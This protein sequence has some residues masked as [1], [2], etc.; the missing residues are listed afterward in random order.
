MLTHTAIVAFG[1]INIITDWWILALPIP[2]VMSLSLE[3]RTKWTICSLFLMGGVVCV[4]SI[5]RLFYAKRF[6]SADPS[7]S[8]PTLYHLSPTPY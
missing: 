5:V 2:I 4:I 3:R 1:V 6:E 8:S 7:C